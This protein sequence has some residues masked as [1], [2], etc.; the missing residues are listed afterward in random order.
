MREPYG[1]ATAGRTGVTR[2]PDG[3]PAEP[4]ES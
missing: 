2:E 3:F 4:E 1:A